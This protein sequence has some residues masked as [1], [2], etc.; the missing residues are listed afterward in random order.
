MK[1]DNQTVYKKKIKNDK[2]V[3]EFELTKHR[4]AAKNK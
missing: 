2:L 3:T 1:C 4:I